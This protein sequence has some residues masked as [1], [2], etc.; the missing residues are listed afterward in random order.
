MWEFE[1]VS[2]TLNSCDWQDEF[3]VGANSHVIKHLIPRIQ[4]FARIED[5]HCTF[6]TRENHSALCNNTGTPFAQS[7]QLTLSSI[8]LAE[9]VR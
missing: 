7:M 2:V 4:A 6:Y 3:L 8:R 5:I 9:S 1:G